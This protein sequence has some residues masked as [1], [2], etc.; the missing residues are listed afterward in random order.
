V[1]GEAGVLKKGFA[2]LRGSL[3]FWGGGGVRSTHTNGTFTFLREIS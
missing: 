1:G 3:G 2:M